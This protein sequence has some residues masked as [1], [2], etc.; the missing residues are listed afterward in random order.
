MENKKQ[1]AVQW[2]INELTDRQNGNGNSKSI[3]EIYKQALQLEREQIISAAADHCY[4]T[5]QLALN[6]AERYYTQTYEC[7]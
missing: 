1:T 5:E 2:L 6:D 7:K 3:D 4:P